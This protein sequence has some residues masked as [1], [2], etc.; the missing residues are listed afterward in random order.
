[1]GEPQATILVVDDEPQNIKLMEALLL[2]RGYRVLRASNGLEAIQ[3]ATQHLPDLILLDVLMPEMNGYE[4]CRYLKAQE[5]TRF[6]PIIM[7]TALGQVQDRIRG[8]EAGAGD[9]L[10]KPVYRDE[11]LARLKTSLRLKQALDQRM[12]ALQQSQ[13]HLA[14]FVPPMVQRLIKAN[15]LAPALEAQEQ[16]V[17]ILF[18]D[19]SGYARLSERYPPTTITALVEHYFSHF[20]DC[21]H[22]HGGEVCETAG[23]GLM[24]FFLDTDAQRHARQAVVTVLDIFQRTLYLN[25]QRAPATD[26]I[27][28]HAGIN[29]GTA[30]VGPMKLSGSQSV[31]WTY[32]VYGAVTNLASRIATVSLP[33]TL[34][35]GPETARRVAGFCIL[36][37][38][39]FHH[40][41]NIADAVLLSQVLGLTAPYGESP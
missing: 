21:I 2:P 23:D 29:S 36:R 10:T 5:T 13:A 12:E 8:I 20:L 32:T 30:L 26:P 39:G 28:V 1:M 37:P 15:P 25:Q 14:K 34:L 22:A 11:L 17:S 3:H 31:K 7:M 16:D 18:V 27:Q 4:A 38:V 33:S 40:F 24:A 9:F 35:I 41:K 19:I 6:I